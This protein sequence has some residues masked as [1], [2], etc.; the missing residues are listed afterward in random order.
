MIYDKIDSSLISLGKPKSFNDEDGKTITPVFYSGAD[1][2]FTLKNKYVKIEKVETNTYGREFVTVK[3]QEFSSIISDIAKKVG[4]NDPVQGDGTFK[5]NIVSKTKFTK[6]VPEDLSFEAC[7][8]ISIP[9]IFTDG[10][11]TSL[12]VH[13][14]QFYVTNIYND[15]L[16]VDMSKISLAI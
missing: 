9:S 3:S 11:N 13:A 6:K 1:L 15:D 10:V 8:S 7:V 14:R 5:I 16:E 12:Q 2:V 4:A